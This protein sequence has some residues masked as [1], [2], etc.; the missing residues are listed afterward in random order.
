MTVPSDPAT[1]SFSN[2]ETRAAMAGIIFAAVSELSEASA[3]GAVCAGGSWSEAMSVQSRTHCEQA[4]VCCCVR[5][6]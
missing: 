6:L 2:A 1:A 3:A 4:N 5:E